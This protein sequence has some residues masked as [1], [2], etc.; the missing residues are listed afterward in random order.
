MDTCVVPVIIVY[1]NVFS[2]QCPI[3][4]KTNEGVCD[5]KLLSRHRHIC[6][7]RVAIG[8]RH[9]SG[10]SSQGSTT[11]DSEAMPKYKVNNA[12]RSVIN[13]AGLIDIYA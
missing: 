7:S 9:N 4:S 3:T 2:A 5:Y 8:K 10:I 6:L 1:F 13:A 11:S 12:K